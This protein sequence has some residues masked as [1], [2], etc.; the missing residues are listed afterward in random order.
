[1]NKAPHKRGTR[2]GKDNPNCKHVE[3]NSSSLIINNA[4]KSLVR[5]TL[6][7]LVRRGS[8]QAQTPSSTDEALASS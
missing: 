4:P 2:L 3:Q 6:Q 8:T 5:D 7:L 1:M